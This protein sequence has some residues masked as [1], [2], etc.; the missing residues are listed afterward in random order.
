MVTLQTIKDTFESPNG[1]RLK[2]IVEFLM[3]IGN[4]STDP[5]KAYVAGGMFCIGGA[6]PQH[7]VWPTKDGKYEFHI[8][9]NVTGEFVPDPRVTMI[10]RYLYS[11]GGVELMQRAY[12]GLDELGYKG[13]KRSLG[14]A[15]N[16][17]G[18]W[19]A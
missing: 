12:Y 2:T 5:S 8:K 7:E 19:S 15:W 1:F 3:E 9:D 13:S 16:G 17:L 10:G 4:E 18:S 11:V 6:I 14:W